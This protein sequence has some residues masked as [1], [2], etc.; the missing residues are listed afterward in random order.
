MSL[1]LQS[2]MASVGA[3]LAGGTHP[4]SGGFVLVVAVL[5]LQRILF[6]SKHE[7]GMWANGECVL[8]GIKPKFCHHC[9]MSHGKVLSNPMVNSAPW[10]PSPFDALQ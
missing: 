8:Q 10:G 1:D 9:R 2:G 7:T 6:F 5:G 3:A 4:P